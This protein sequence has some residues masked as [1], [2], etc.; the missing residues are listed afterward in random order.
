[1]GEK[2]DY[3]KEVCYLAVLTGVYTS[4]FLP[5]YWE[6]VLAFILLALSLAGMSIKLYRERKYPLLF[7]MDVLGIAILVR[8]S[9]FIGR[10]TEIG[11]GKIFLGV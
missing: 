11:V 9:G 5:V 1:M 8:M 7:L 3:C 2:A 4:F 6:T 10:W